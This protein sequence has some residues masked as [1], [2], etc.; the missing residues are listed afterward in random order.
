MTVLELIRQLQQVTKNPNANVLL[1]SGQFDAH[2][3]MHDSFG[4]PDG[5]E[6]MGANC[7]FEYDE[8]NVYIVS[9]THPGYRM[10][11]ECPHDDDPYQKAASQ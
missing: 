11:M 6:T 2:K 3:A 5:V 8:Q 9:S 4:V 10:D 1:V 7:V